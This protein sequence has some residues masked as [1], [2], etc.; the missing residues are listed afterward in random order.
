VRQALSYGMMN[1]TRVKLWMTIALLAPIALAGVVFTTASADSIQCLGEASC[2]SSSDNDVITGTPFLEDEIVALAG[3]DVVYSFEG[4]DRIS[5]NEGDDLIY[6]G[7]GSDVA[8][9]GSGDDTIIGDEGDDFLDGNL[10]DDRIVGGAGND[11]I[12]GSGGDDNLVGDEGNDHIYGGPGSDQFWCNS[13]LDTVHDYN[14][15]EGDKIISEPDCE[16]VNSAS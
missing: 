16:N 1:L 13:G 4:A 9:G 3:D 5:G 12:S 8:N 2:Y 6:T 14:P 7:P 15:A 10:G 11:I